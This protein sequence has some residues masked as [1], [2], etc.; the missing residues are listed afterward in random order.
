MMH[1]FMVRYTHILKWIPIVNFYTLVYWGMRSAFVTH[2]KPTFG[3]VMK[4]LGMIFATLFLA[5]GVIWVLLQLKSSM[6][7]EEAKGII[8]PL[9]ASFCFFPILITNETKTDEQG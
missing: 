8:F 2:T 9:W 6:T 1:D 7:Q 4:T 3:M 5:S